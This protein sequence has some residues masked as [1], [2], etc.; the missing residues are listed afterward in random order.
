MRGCEQPGCCLYCACWGAAQ[1]QQQSTNQQKHGISLYSLKS[2]NT[3]CWFKVVMGCACSDTA[4]SG[5]TPM[6]LLYS[7]SS[8]CCHTVSC[9]PRHTG[10]V[11]HLPQACCALLL[12]CICAWLLWVLALVAAC[13]QSVPSACCSWLGC[14]LAAFV[15]PAQCVLGGRP[16]RVAV[17]CGHLVCCASNR[18][19]LPL[20]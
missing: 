17:P 14:V 7:C 9:N 11:H 16:W 19:L 3:Q 12:S 5:H 13:E 18:A 2:N 1:P 20:L 4:V 8:T 10:G 6:S 15:L